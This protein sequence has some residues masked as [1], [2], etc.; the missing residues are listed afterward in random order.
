MGEI[1]IEGPGALDF[2]NYLVTNDVTKLAVNQALYCAML[3][4]NGGIVDDL[5]IY[6][7][8]AIRFFLVVNAS[9]TDKDFKHIQSVL[10]S[11]SGTKPTVVNQSSQ[12]SQIAIQGPASEKILQR[13]TETKLSEIKTYWCAAGKIGLV[14]GLIA[15]TGYT[16]EDG[17]EIYVPW[18]SGPEIFRGLL[19]VGAQ[20]GILPCGLGA[21]DT[22]RLE[23]KY[24]LYG[25]ELTDLTSPLETGLGWVT[26]LAKENF[27][28]KPALLAQK[29]RGITRSLVGIQS[30]GRAIP[31]QGYAIFAADKTTQI[32][33]VTSGT[34]SPSLKHPIGIAL[35]DRRCEAVG[36]KL[37]VKVREEF[38]DAVV[39]KTPFLI[40]NAKGAQK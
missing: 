17:F 19:S 10:A 40:K 26:K 30:T 1:L 39:V 3:N 14:D 11:Y 32:G 15:R 7:T 38:A 23:M 35:V 21:R 5:V 22:L 28:G 36:T 24:A 16:G 6:R 33:V 29:E 9:N 31:R 34:S 2:V 37:F 18:E 13:L 20:D 8:G 12:F 27:V 4:V 25:H